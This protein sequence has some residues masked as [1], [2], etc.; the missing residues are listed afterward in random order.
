M[1]NV[2]QSKKMRLNPEPLKTVPASQREAWTR[3]WTPEPPCAYCGSIR[4]RRHDA[5]DA[6]GH[7][8]YECVN[9]V[10]CDRRQRE[11]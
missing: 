8:V 3:E 9:R 11:G 10:Q 2:R 6:L 1:T 5:T 4:A 7:K